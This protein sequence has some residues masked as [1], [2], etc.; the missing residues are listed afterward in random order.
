MLKKAILII[1]SCVYVLQMYSQHIATYDV[2]MNC[3]LDTTNFKEV[4]TYKATVEMSSPTT[5]NFLNVPQMRTCWLIKNWSEY[6]SVVKK[7][8]LSPSVFN[9]YN[10][11]VYVAATGGGELP[12]VE[13][14]VYSR[15]N[16]QYITSYV[17]PMT[18]HKN[19]LYVIVSALIPKEYCRNI[20][21][22]YDFDKR[23]VELMRK[24]M[25]YNN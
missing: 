2:C 5:S 18:L 23:N 7:A 14:K 13:I 16:E 20:S 10:L 22:I 19:M 21:R 6:S 15:D 17:M 25:E 12:S 4:Y 9:Q 24:A 11:L 8:D 1:A 3:K